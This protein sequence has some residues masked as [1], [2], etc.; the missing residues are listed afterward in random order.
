M[1]FNLLVLLLFPLTVCSAQLGIRIYHEE[2][3]NGYHIYADSDEFCP[4][5]LNIEFSATNFSIEGGK[6][7]I[8]VIDAL[9]KKKLLTTLKVAKSG[10]ASKMSYSTLANYGDHNLESYDE[11]Y[12]YDLPYKTALKFK[13]EQGYNG[14]FSHKNENSLDFKMPVGTEV[15]AIREGVVVN[16]VD[17]Y[18]RGCGK[19]E[20]KIYNNF[21]IVYHPDGTFAEYTHIKQNGAKVAAGETIS[22][23]Q[24]IALSGNVGWSTGPHLHLMVY[25]QRM[26]KRETLQTRFRTGRGDKIEFLTEKSEYAREY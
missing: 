25:K 7:Q 24:V 3:E 26:T 14:K 9:E 13:I 8:F 22:K 5:S 4:V 19:E 12:V 23:G 20:C 1:K 17:K 10:K 6:N 16:V 18:K 21:I 2:I 15:A 11:D